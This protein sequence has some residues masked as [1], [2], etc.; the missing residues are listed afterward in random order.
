MLGRG[1]DSEEF[2]PCRSSPRP[3]II[4]RLP[5]NRLVSSYFLRSRCGDGGD[6]SKDVDSCSLSLHLTGLRQFF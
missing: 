6:R 5:P 3:L 2:S 4:I 1:R